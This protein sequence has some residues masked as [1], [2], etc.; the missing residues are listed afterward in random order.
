MKTFIIRNL[1]VSAVAMTFAAPELLSAA[2]ASPSAASPS[3]STPLAQ[4]MEQLD[5]QLDSVFADTFRD[6]GDSFSN[7]AFAS[8][9]DLRDQKDKY[10]VRVYVPGSDTS[11]VSAKVEGDT[12]HITASGDQST[13]NSSQSERYE[14]VVGLPGPVQADKMHIERKENLMVVS[15]PKAKEAATAARTKTNPPG[16]NLAG[17][18]DAL[19]QQM[20]RM[21]G[22]MDQLLADSF[23]ED[24]D[25][26][27]NNSAA[28]DFG[29]AVH[30][31]DQKS[32]YVVHFNL[33]DK[34][35]KDVNVQLENGQLR[36]TAS[37]TENKQNG[38]ASS[39]QSG[40][41][42]QLMTLPGPVQS[43]GMKVER[44]NGT[45]IVTVPK[46]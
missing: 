40:A 4:R 36:L 41:Y 6:F 44:E 42:E 22:R 39:E 16:N 28:M 11:K 30:V 9:V 18:D 3:P 2:T 12:L 17:I 37:D 26:L 5:K 29:S 43:K 8:S 1:I 10:V 20:A 21:R 38:S 46:A 31:D 7:S 24:E 27:T 34:D 13:K 14:Q 33:P 32:D 19:I 35:L 45:I 15:L 25:N 23:P